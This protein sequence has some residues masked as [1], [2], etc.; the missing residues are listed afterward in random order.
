MKVLVQ[1]L[2]EVPATIELA[3]EKER[4]DVTYVVCSEYQLKKIAS[5]AG[6]TEPNESVIRGQPKN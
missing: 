3:L 2:G 5:A 6:Y 1:G 4:P